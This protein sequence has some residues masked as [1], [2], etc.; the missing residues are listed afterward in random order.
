MVTNSSFLSTRRMIASA[1]DNDRLTFKWSRRPC[2]DSR[3]RRSGHARR[4]GAEV[5]RSEVAALAVDPST[6]GTGNLYPRASR[7]GSAQS[8]VAHGGELGRLPLGYPA[9][10]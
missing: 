1:S 3:G 7:I 10:G 2:G 4:D 9:T 6:D 8:Y 5:L